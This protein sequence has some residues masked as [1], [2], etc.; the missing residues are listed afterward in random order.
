M[1]SCA[2]L[3]WHLRLYSDASLLVISWAAV[4]A[5]FAGCAEA[6]QELLCADDLEADMGPMHMLEKQQ[7]CWADSKKV[8][9]RKKGFSCA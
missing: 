6:H 9:L 7:K 2:M 4:A 1:S 3:S 8:L 5:D